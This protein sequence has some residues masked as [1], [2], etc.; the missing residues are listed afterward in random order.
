MTFW[1]RLRF[2]FLVFTDWLLGT[3]LVEREL[4][5]LQRQ[6]QTYEAYASAIL[7]QM[8]AL[9]HVLHVVQVELC[10]LYLRQRYLLRSNTWLRFDPAEDADEE[11]SLDLLIA[12]LVKHDL[13][14]V[15]T[16]A[17]GE[18]AYAY[19]LRPDWSSLIDLLSTWK[20]RLDPVMLL[21]LGEMRSKEN[22]EVR[23]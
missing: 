21:W 13:A 20:D 8:Q 3:R 12:R 14:T 22:G 19:H 9:S 17:V 4:T 15:R 10:V 7:Q 18:Q 23:H 5:R 1:G 2:F 16:E 11:R 6:V